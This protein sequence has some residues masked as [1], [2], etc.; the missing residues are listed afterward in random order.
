MKGIDVKMNLKLVDWAVGDFFFAFHKCFLVIKRSGLSYKDLITCYTS[1][2]RPV[3]EYA[4]PVFHSN[5][6]KEQCLKIESIQ[7]GS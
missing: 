5:L 4:A 7:K 1:V 3:L 6:T 2:V